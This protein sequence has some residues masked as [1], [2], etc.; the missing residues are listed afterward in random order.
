MLVNTAK[1]VSEQKELED[2]VAAA[3]KPILGPDF[4]VVAAFHPTMEGP[5]SSAKCVIATGSDINK[6]EFW[7]TKVLVVSVNNLLAHWTGLV[8]GAVPT[9]KQPQ[10]QGSEFQ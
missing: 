3:L 8:L 9:T 1:E 2:K 4:V 6:A 5:V 7:K 10:N